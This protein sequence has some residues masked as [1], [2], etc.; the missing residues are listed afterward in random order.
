LR[1]R[2]YDPSQC[3]KGRRRR[4]SP[5]SSS[6]SERYSDHRS[7]LATPLDHARGSDRGVPDRTPRGPGVS[8][9]RDQEIES[10][11]REHRRH[12]ARRW[13]TAQ[14]P[15]LRPDHRRAEMNSCRQMKQT[16]LGQQNSRERYAIFCCVKRSAR[17]SCKH[18]SIDGRRD[19]NDPLDSREDVLP[20]V[21]V[22]REAGSRTGANRPSYRASADLFPA[23]TWFQK[24]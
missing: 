15:G 9:G 10:R 3:E 17:S 6:S 11:V 13:V 4:R 8:R 16:E 23:G 22:D 12:G 24:M 7:P 2:R 1:S 5:S 14:D 18:N 20:V 21:P 19:R